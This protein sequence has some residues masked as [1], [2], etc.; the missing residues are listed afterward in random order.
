MFFLEANGITHHYALEARKHKP[1]LVFCNSLGSDLRIWDGLV[2]HLAGDFSIIRYDS[3]GHGL[4]DAPA[5]PYSLDDLMLDLV[6]VLDRLEIKDAAV[7]GLSVGGLIAQRFAI[8]HPQR[9]RALVL[10]DTG[11]RIGSLASWEERIATVRQSGL[12]PLVDF[13]MERWFTQTFRDHR[14]VELRGYA[15]MLHRMPVEGYLGTCYA[16][17]DADLTAQAP[18]IG[19]PTLVLCGNQDIATPPEL[20]QE[21][22]RAIPGARFSLIGEAGHLSCIEQPEAMARRMIDFF[23]EVNLV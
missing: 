21:P 5:P 6:G 20:G 11:L 8:S 15:N 1:V 16:L 13:S 19:K 7:C 18:G 22:A 14:N 17:R 2:P 10:C 9:L 12:A 23:R 4:S 3:R